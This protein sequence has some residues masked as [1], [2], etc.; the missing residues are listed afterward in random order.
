MAQ[1]RFAGR[2]VVITGGAQGIG[3]AVSLAFAKEGAS[4]IA[5]DIDE[6][7]GRELVADM[8]ALPG[9][10]R[11]FVPMDVA[12][13]NSVGELAELVATRFGHADILVNNAG[14]GDTRPLAQRS[15]EEWD[16][17]L[18]V[19]LRAPYM[20]AKY[21]AD[22]L[23]AST[24]GPGIIINIASTRA[25]M[26][27]ANTEPYSASK[28]GLL[29]LTHA[30]AVSLGPHVRVNAISP[31]WIETANWQRADK[32][33]KAAHRP[34]DLSQHPVGRVGTPPDIAAAVLFLASPDA[35]FITGANLVVDGGMTIKM[36]YEA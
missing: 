5:A 24:P 31:G 9:K 13:Q 26:S 8:V 14:I 29:A 27:E 4:V 12:S 1:R 3:R 19:N 20:C 10:E 23:C 36:I 15:M 21:F 7:A 30:L 11:I 33:K 17:V 25:L 22:Q 18:A 34:Q 32:R 35:G 2:V 6:A 28:G 16:R